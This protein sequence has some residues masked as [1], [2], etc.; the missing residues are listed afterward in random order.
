MALPA[1]AP[2][3]LCPVCLLK[4]EALTPPS[5]A[6]SAAPGRPLPVSGE[7]F[8]GYRIE[9]LLGQGGMGQAYV[10]EEL[11]TGRRVALKVMNHAL[12]SESDRKRFLREGRLAASVNHSNVVYVHGT[13]E[14]DGVPV[15]AMELVHGGTLHDRLKKE[16]PLPVADA[17]EAA[18]QIIAGLEAAHAAGVLHRDIKPANCFVTEDGLVKVGDFG[19]SISTLA[20][21]ESLLTA[22][23]SVLGTPAYASPEQLRGEDLTVASDIYSVGATLYH[24]LTG[25]TPFE[26]TDFV[27]LITEVLDRQPAAPSAVRREIPEELSRILLRCLAKDRKTR[28]ATYGELRD[29]LL[30][31]SRTEFAP[32]RPAVRFAANLVDDLLANGPGLLFL[33]YWSIDPLDS[34]VRERTWLA[35]FQWLP[36]FL[37]HLIYYAACEGLWGAGLGKSFFGLRVISLDRDRPGFLKALVRAMVFMIPFTV[38]SLVYM[39]LVSKEAMRSALAR[40]GHVLSDW[41]GLILFA[42]LFITMRQRNGYAALH[43]LLSRTRVTVRPKSEP[44]P[45]L[46]PARCGCPI[47]FGATQPKATDAVPARGAIDR[48]GPYEVH[49][50]LWRRDGEELLLGSDAA[51]KRKVWVHLRPSGAPAVTLD[52]QDLS[53]P[54]RLRWLGCG[55]AERHQWDAYEAVEGAA[56]VELARRPQRWRAV[57]FWL[58]DLAREG[59]V[60]LKQMDAPP[61]IGLD[62]I[63]ISRSGHAVWLEFPVPSAQGATADPVETLTEPQDLQ[64]FLARLARQALETKPPLQPAAGKSNVEIAAPIPLPA[65]TFLSSLARGTLREPEYIIGNLESLAGRPAEITRARRVWTLV[66]APA[67]VLLLSLLAVALFLFEEL[68]WRRNWANAYPDKASLAVVAAL[69][70]EAVSSEQAGLKSGKDNE[71]IRA[72]LVRHYGPILTNQAFWANEDLASDY[73]LGQRDLLTLAVTAHRPPAPEILAEA[74]R[75]VPPMI[76]QQEQMTRQIPFVFVASFPLATPWLWALVELASALIAGKCR[77]P[78]LLG[79]G[80]VNR[81]GAPASRLRLFWR[82][83]VVWIPMLTYSFLVFAGW[84]AHR[85]TLGTHAPGAG[86]GLLGQFL[87]AAGAAGLLGVLA[88]AVWKPERGLADRL[89]GTWLVLR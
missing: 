67:A 10:A 69:Y 88:W 39:M 68:H 26:A 53:R 47:G 20:R 19:L 13:T 71:I 30:P 44:R 76:S 89:A 8:G 4:S 49:C 84:I 28:H 83:M 22:Q 48:L 37:W 56:L 6:P 64:N 52:R 66:L 73:L 60:A 70:L 46:D 81:R 23:G 82:W 32:A 31:F 29:A 78:H 55:R 87:L 59:E 65:H 62:R 50:R 12:G 86:S 79:I 34:L 3:G 16:G 9:R 40:D 45:G 15:I 14:V 25:R 1:N 27:K 42:L 36:F 51:L 33:L 41:L 11:A 61:P 2:A 80:V 17:V 77:L 5:V 24:L 74:E 43:D 57:R 54:G 7:R 38:P 75:T 85:L 18:L 63:W 72:Y 35:V 21:G 58:L